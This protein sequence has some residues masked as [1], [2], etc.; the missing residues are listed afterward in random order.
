MKMYPC[1]IIIPNW[2]LKDYLIDC[3]GSV[4]DMNRSGELHILVVD[5][6]SID[7]SV[8]AVEEMFGDKIK[9]ISLKANYGYSYAI[10]RGIEKA[11]SNKA[12]SVL[13]LNN[14]TIVESELLI[15]LEKALNQIE[16]GG[17]FSPAIYN[18]KDGS[19]WRFG[20]REHA[21]LKIPYRVKPDSKDSMVALDYVTG[22][23]MLIT[24]NV[25]HKIGLF[26]ERFFMYYEDADFCWRARQARFGVFGIANARVFH[27]VSTSGA[28]L[29][30]AKV[31]WQFYSRALFYRKKLS[32]VRHP[33]VF[34]FIFIKLISFSL[35]NLSISKLKYIHLAWRATW[36]AC[37]VTI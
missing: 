20:D 7:N 27:H 24:S 36:Q 16:N 5:N 22:C 13:L 4:V 9:Q 25:F 29:N 30:D 23:A 37:Q 31:F 17:I 10:N 33:A 6:G 14:D 11:L 8:N 2:N 26:D 19:L 1:W 18:I 28:F 21:L 32:L 3:L 15:K 35:R 34:V 12:S